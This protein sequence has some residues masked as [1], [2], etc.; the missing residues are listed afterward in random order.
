MQAILI[1]SLASEGMS[2]SPVFVNAGGR[3]PHFLGVHVGHAKDRD[4]GAHSGV[5]LVAP[6]GKLLQLLQR[7]DLVSARERIAQQV[8]GS[9][10]RFRDMRHRLR[11][12]LSLT[13]ES[14]A[15]EDDYYEEHPMQISFLLVSPVG[16]PGGVRDFWNELPARPLADIEEVAAT[17][18]S[19]FSEIAWTEHF[20]RRSGWGLWRDGETYANVDIYADGV[21]QVEAIWLDF[22]LEELQAATGRIR[23]STIAINA[24]RQALGATHLIDLH[25]DEVLH[26]PSAQTRPD[27]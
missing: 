25:Q 11:Y 12:G 20:Y 13:E 9:A 8:S 3:D 5:S 23:P 18:A 26:R 2:G 16:E 19:F 27:E 6:A 10:W 17:V 22:D 14:F 15:T 4:G 1:E 7:S 24:L 21:S